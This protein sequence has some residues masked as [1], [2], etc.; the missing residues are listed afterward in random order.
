M[1]LTLTHYCMDHSYFLPLLICTLPSPRVRNLVP[2]FHYL[3]NYS[4]PVSRKSGIRINTYSHG[5]QVCQLECAA[6]VQF[7]LCLA[8]QFS[9]V[10]RSALFPPTPPIVRLFHTFVIQLKFFLSHCALDPGILQLPI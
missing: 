4:V 2:T 7:L 9:E 8:F 5:K 3:F 10:L 1:S 6:S